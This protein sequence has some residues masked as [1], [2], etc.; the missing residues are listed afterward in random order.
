[1][2]LE[3]AT[4]PVTKVR[5]SDR[6][7]YR[8]GHLQI[9]KQ[10]LLSIVLDDKKIVSADLD[11][12][13]PGEETRIVN[14][15]DVVEPRIKVAG[16]GCVFPG[17]LGPVDAVGNGRTHRLS[18]MAVVV[19]ATYR[20]TILSGT[21]AGNSSIID[22]W[23]PLARATPFGSTINVVLTIKL[24]DGVTELEAHAAIQL[25]E[26]K[27][28][29]R[30]AE[31][32]RELATGE[33]EVFGIG[34]VD[35]SL[36]RVVY[37][38]SFLTNWHAPHSLVA[39]YGLPIRESLPTYIHPNE[40]LDGALT[41]DTRIGSGEY[42]YT[43]E[44]LNKGIVYRLLREHGKRVN[45]L[46]VILQRTRFE[47]EHGKQVTALC[48]AQMAKLLKAEGAIVT[49]TVMSGANL[50]DVMLT[51]QACEQKGL[52]TVF[53]TPEWGGRDGTEP[54]FVFT[55]PEADAIVS[56]GSTDREYRLPV[57]KKLIGINKGELVQLYA[58]DQWLSPADEL[59]LDDT[60]LTGTT[61]W[62]GA[63]KYTR[64][65]Y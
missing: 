58:G 39:Y 63:G 52:K 4:Y 3:L 31:T 28:A 7:A 37:I 54:P 55:V 40:Y 35:P 18:G 33:T 1:M 45:L 62:W 41:K 24:L 60:C 61:D 17:I 25:A 48:A 9:D 65:Q 49:R 21:A 12:A 23:G 34:D 53:L 6:T 27:V 64:V 16:S 14:V 32:T 26:F 56:T 10:E 5:W 46:G 29:R 44:W 59:T 36:P 47:A 19:S 2:N 22:M 43:W 38:D 30:L 20:P 51:V 50:V 57:P 11:I 13:L 8:D 42:T 15:R